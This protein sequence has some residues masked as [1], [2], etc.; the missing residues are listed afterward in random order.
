[1]DGLA[2]MVDPD[3]RIRTTPQPKLQHRFLVAPFVP[4]VM[5]RR[6]HRHGAGLVVIKL[7]APVLTLAEAPL[8][9]IVIALIGDC[10]ESLWHMQTMIAQAECE[11]RQGMDPAAVM[12]ATPE[13]PCNP[14]ELE[15]ACRAQGVL[16][17]AALGAGQDAV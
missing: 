4:A 8:L 10:R 15:R 11:K 5:R 2:G 3:L 9:R 7:L 1:M 17:G 14:G 6:S 16:I 13:Q 12:A